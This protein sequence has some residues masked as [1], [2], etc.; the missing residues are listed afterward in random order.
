MAKTLADYILNPFFIV[1]YFIFEDDF[2]GGKQNTQNMFYFILNL[3]LSIIIVF[4]GCI[5]NEFL[6]LFCFNLEHDTHRQVSI[7]AESLENI[8]FNENINDDSSDEDIDEE[9]GNK[10]NQ[11]NS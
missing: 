5:Y 1:Y 9:N 8:E 10:N 7:R 2:I 6:V 11:N 3:I 4:C